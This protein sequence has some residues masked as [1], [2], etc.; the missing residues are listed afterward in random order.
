MNQKQEVIS[1]VEQL[2][3]ATPPHSVTHGRRIARIE[4]SEQRLF[5]PVGPSSTLLA[6]EESF[7]TDWADS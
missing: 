6:S 1:E 4:Q 5:V 7:I 2:R 3:R